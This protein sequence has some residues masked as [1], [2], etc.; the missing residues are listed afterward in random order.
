MSFQFRKPGV[1]VI[2]LGAQDTG[3]LF[4]CGALHHFIR[5]LLDTRRSWWKATVLASLAATE[6]S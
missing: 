2:Y 5:S 3:R 4:V 1:L 6:D